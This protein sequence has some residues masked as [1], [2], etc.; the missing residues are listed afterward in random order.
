MRTQPILKRAAGKGALFLGT[1]LR[2]QSRKGKYLSDTTDHHSRFRLLMSLSWIWEITRAKKNSNLNK[3]PKQ[4]LQHFQAPT[5]NQKPHFLWSKHSRSI[6]VAPTGGKTVYCVTSIQPRLRH[7]DYIYGQ[8]IHQFTFKLNSDKHIKKVTQHIPIHI[9]TQD[10]VITPQELGSNVISVE[11]MRPNALRLGVRSPSIPAS[12]RSDFHMLL[13]VTKYLYPYKNLPCYHESRSPQSTEWRHCFVHEVETMLH[14]IIWLLR[15]FSY[16]IILLVVLERS[17]VLIQ[18]STSSLCLRTQPLSFCH[19]TKM[20]QLR[21]A[22]RE[23]LQ[24]M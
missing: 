18:T 7:L 2:W 12:I 17:S 10:T 14:K 22:A 8:T 15:F 20:L 21:G 4:T 3:H 23:Q 13:E 16:C 9:P 11:Q 24:R 19:L 5:I 6:L 1:S